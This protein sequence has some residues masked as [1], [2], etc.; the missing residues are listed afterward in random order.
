MTTDKKMSVGLH[1]WKL[2][3]QWKVLSTTTMEVV[4]NLS[5]FDIFVTG[6]ASIAAYILQCSGNWFY[7]SATFKV[8]VTLKLD[9]LGDA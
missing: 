1:A 2:R 6:E 4:L 8:S 9:I 7:P 3:V 5:H